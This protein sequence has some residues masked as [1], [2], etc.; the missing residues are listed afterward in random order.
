MPCR[1]MNDLEGEICDE[2]LCECALGNNILS[3][4]LDSEEVLLLNI[5]DHRVSGVA[6]DLTCLICRDGIR[7]IFQALFHVCFDLV[8][9]VEVTD[10]FLDLRTLHSVHGI[11]FDDLLSDGVFEGGVE[12]IVVPQGMAKVQQFMKLK[13]DKTPETRVQM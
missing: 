9:R 1:L 10:E 4:D 13:S 3:A 7:K 6:H 12:Q 11:V 8:H 5:R 2:E